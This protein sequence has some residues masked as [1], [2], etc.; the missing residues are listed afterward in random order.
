M[1]QD[2]L[3]NSLIMHPRHDHGQWIIRKALL[4]NDLVAAVPRPPSTIDTVDVP[5]H[6]PGA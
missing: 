6:P 4:V 1:R 2:E 3:A 5:A